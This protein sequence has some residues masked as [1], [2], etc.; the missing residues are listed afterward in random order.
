MRGS[1]AVLAA[2][3]VL[4]WCLVAQDTTSRPVRRRTTAEDLQLFGQVLNQ[5]RVN[6]PDSVDTHE[7]LM[8]AIQGM[9]SSAD[10][11]SYVIPAVRL[12]PERETLRRSGKLGWVFINFRFVDG[13]VVVANAYAGS[14]AARQ[15]VL[16]GDELIAVDGRPLPALSA[17][18]V[19][20]ILS[21]Q[22]GTTVELQF[23]RRRADGS[24]TRI[25]RVFEREIREPSSA[26]SVATMLDQR[27]GYVRITTF[28][29][30]KIADD[31]DRALSQLE[32]RGM[33]QLVLDLR[34]NGGGS[35][36]EAARVAG[37]FLPEGMVVYTATGRKA[38]VN[39]TMK[40]KRSFWKE[41]RSY[42]I[43]VLV[44]EGTASASEL[45]AG[46]LQDHDR[47][48]IVGQ[49]SFGKALLMYGL[50][51]S[52]GSL[53][54]LVVGHVRTPCGRVVQRQ[55][56]SVTRRVY[57]RLA[58]ADR[59]TA[60]RPSCKSDKGRTLYGGG[61]IYPDEILPR[62]AEFPL[63]LRRTLEVG[64]VLEWL[65]SYMQRAQLPQ[66][67]ETFVQQATVPADEIERF[68]AMAATHAIAVPADSTARGLLKRRLLS[69]I[70]YAKWGESGAARMDA[71]LDAD[72]TRVL[73]LFD[74]AAGLVR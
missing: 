17:D 34:D 62:Q 47:A 8:A 44:N 38:D 35:V 48:L 4:P 68:V 43:I 16:P 19:D 41:S 22:R 18:E 45:V 10:P 59:D 36:D 6:H 25:T 46:A 23:E 52:D 3:A 32:K 56:R 57:Y 73:T 72:L 1:L 40:V 65:G 24:L 53:I 55:Y 15:D 14:K 29:G 33:T 11:H 70:A 13:A 71:A 5:I 37:A 54:M 58:G 26:V 49:P 30:D 63:W 21:G 27:T 20:L 50:P 51:L 9:I 39:A 61:G 74:R 69:A 31:V 28:A 12:S 67:A 42:P 7:L 66:S 2:T 60:G 64:V